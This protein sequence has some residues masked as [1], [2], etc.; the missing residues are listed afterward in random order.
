MIGNGFEF[1]FH[2]NRTFDVMIRKEEVERPHFPMIL[3]HFCTNSTVV[4]V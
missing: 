3:P 1:Y 2:Q 4:K